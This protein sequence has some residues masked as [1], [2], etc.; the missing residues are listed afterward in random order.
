MRSL[1]WA[2]F[3]TCLLFIAEPGFP[4]PT[5]GAVMPARNRFQWGLAVNSIINYR[6]KGATDKVDIKSNQ[7]F[8]TLAYGLFDRLSLD[9]KIGLGDVRNDKTNNTDLDYNAGWGGGYGFRVKVYENELNRVKVICGVHH[10]SV[11]PASE[12]ADSVEYKSIIDDNQFDVTISRKYGF[13]IPY[14]GCKVS[15]SR[16]LRRDNNESSSLHSKVKMGIILGYDVETSKD[17][18]LNLEMRLI[19]ETAFNVGIS[20]IF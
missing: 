1:I 16:I 2:G 9:G 19:D 12:D 10:I 6:M 17:T 14:I 13:G 15:K 18:F 8:L 5:C 4:A 20:H 3:L 11:H 7:V